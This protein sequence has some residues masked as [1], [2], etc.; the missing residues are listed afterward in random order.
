MPNI[1]ILGETIPDLCLCPPCVLDQG[2]RSIELLLLGFQDRPWWSARF[3]SEEYR[4]SAFMRNAT[5]NPI[6]SE[7]LRYVAERMA[8]FPADENM[9]VSEG[10]DKDDDDDDE[11]EKIEGDSNSEE[12]EKMSIKC[13]FPLMFLL[14]FESTYHFLKFSFQFFS[15]KLTHSMVYGGRW[16]RQRGRREG[17]K[18]AEYQNPQLQNFSTSF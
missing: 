1:F 17:I 11:E 2:A 18:I 3:S 14:F 5:L 10:S 16:R 15:H 13:K 6:P 12:D 8:S 9:S 7:V 4:T